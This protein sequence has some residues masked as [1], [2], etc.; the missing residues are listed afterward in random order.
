MIK[1]PARSISI[2]CPNPLYTSG[3]LHS[4]GIGSV[5]RF[6]S[7][8]DGKFFKLK[9]KTLIR[10]HIMWCVILVC[11]VCLWP[12]YGFPGKNGL[13]FKREG[14]RAKRAIAAM[15]GPHSLVRFGDKVRKKLNYQIGPKRSDLVIKLVSVLFGKCTIL[16]VTKFWPM[17]TRLPCGDQWKTE[18]SGA[19]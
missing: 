8:F 17:E 14:N 2:S 1:E 5:C 7:I 12:F 19:F 13:N 16:V 18:K 4:R 11:T 6:Y 9:L 15:H 10:H 3:L